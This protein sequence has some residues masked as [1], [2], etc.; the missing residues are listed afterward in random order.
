VELSTARSFLFAP[1]NEE[2]KLRK[3]LAAGADAVIA[4]LEDGVSP[5]RRAEAR[6]VVERVLGEVE[7]GS[8]RLLRVNPP[9]TEWFAE[10]L[11]L[12]GR[13]ELDGLVLPKATPSSVA[14]L[15][16][17]PPVV[18][19]VESAAG[20]SLAVETARQPRVAVLAL[21]SHD[22]SAELRLAARPDQLELLFARSQVV[23]ASATAGLRAPIDTVYLDTRDESGL[24]D[25]CRLARTLGFRGKLC[26]HPAQLAAVHEV[27]A[28][29]PAEVEWAR[30]VVEAHEEGL[31]EGRGAV[32][33][34][35]RMIDMPIVKQAEQL[36]AE[37]GGGR[38]G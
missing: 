37:A 27:F 36:L 13:L 23:L 24:N 21:G 14:G 15:G 7:T 22:L 29:S 11:A 9:E 2:R 4:D 6:E 8:V 28:P 16:A 35:G 20:L 25:E 5:D 31:R 12:A 17:G 33:L 3:A 10:D 30:R 1:G 19:I 26:I 34:D 32:A 38:D 18:A